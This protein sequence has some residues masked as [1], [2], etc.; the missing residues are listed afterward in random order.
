MNLKIN[1]VKRNWTQEE[2]ARQSGIC[3]LTISKIERNG[4]ENIQVYI[5]KKIAKALNLT[6]KELFFSDEE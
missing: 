4:I 3:R 1:R 5:L 6:V 2:L